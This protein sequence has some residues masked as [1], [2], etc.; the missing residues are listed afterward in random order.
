MRNVILWVVQIIFG[1]GFIV[2]GIL[3][4][5][6]PDGLP[7]TMS[8]MYDLPTTVHV[9]AGTAEVLGGIGLILPSVTRIRPDLTVWAAVGLA[10]MMVLGAILHMVRGEWDALPGN[11]INLVGVVFIAYGRNTLEPIEPRS[12]EPGR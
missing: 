9:I 7:E 10:I 4:F 12:S 8:W 2:F 3:H 1:L 11:V 5:T 6:L